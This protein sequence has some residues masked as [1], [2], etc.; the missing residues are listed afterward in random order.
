MDSVRIGG[1]DIA[2]SDE[3]DGPPTVLLPGFQS[4]AARW[5]AFGYHDAMPD[6]RLIAVDPLG[7]GRSSN[8]TDSV[9]YSAER[10]VAEVTG[11]LDSLQIEK[12]VVWGF[13]RG[14]MIAALC[15]ELA[16][17]RCSAVI[18]GASPLGAALDLTYPLLAAGVEVLAADDWDTYW[19]GFPIPLPP[20]IKDYLQSTNHAPSNAAAIEGMIG[21]RDAHPDAGLAPVDVPRMA[22]F[23]SG[24][25][26]ADTLRG[27]L[28]AHDVEYHEGSWDG[29]AAT[30]ADAPGVVAAVRPFLERHGV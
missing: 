21:W 8:E 3:G 10:A 9:H 27:E 7:H 15:A 24:E 14:G 11:V 29:H 17:E 5:Q 30:M 19:A 2:F 16:P 20:E 23:G 26:F 1:H 4:N 28:V 13:S 25:V 18:V 6:R 12:A 22:Y